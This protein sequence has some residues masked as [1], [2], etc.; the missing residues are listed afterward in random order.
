M[1]REG[2][3]R[4]GVKGKERERIRSN[5]K[6][7]KSRRTPPKKKTKKQTNVIWLIKVFWG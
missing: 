6:K 7:Q 3:M 2:Y 1:W 5:E 4:R